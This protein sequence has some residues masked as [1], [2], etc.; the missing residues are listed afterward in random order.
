MS[1]NDLKVVVCD[2]LIEHLDDELGTE[3]FISLLE[4]MGFTSEE[5]IR[6]DF[7][8]EDNIKKY[9]SKKRG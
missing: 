5:M 4:N 6:M 8:D 7:T 3:G 2:C 1:K 9:F